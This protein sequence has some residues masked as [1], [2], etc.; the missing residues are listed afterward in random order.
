MRFK[1]RIPRILTKRYWTEPIVDIEATAQAN[2]KARTDLESELDKRLS[3]VKI[4][5]GT[6]DEL[7]QRLGFEI[8]YIPLDYQNNSLI[9]RSSD[10]ISWHIEDYSLEFK[11]FLVEQNIVGLV[12]VQFTKRYAHSYNAFGIPVGRMNSE[13]TKRSEDNQERK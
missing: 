5:Q 2:A 3:D 12:D 11:K 10:G 6:Q 4:Y 8:G 1:P 9:Y 13:E 7:E